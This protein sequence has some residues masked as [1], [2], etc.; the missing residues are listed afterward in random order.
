MTMIK[1]SK[2]TRQKLKVQAAELGMTLIDYLKHLADK[3]ETK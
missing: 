1:L 3:Q 2:E